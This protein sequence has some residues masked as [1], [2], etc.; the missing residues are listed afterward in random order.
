MGATGQLGN[1]STST[2]LVPV[3]VVDLVSVAGSVSVIAAG[4]MSTCAIARGR[5]YCWGYNS[6]GQ[7]G[8]NS[9]TNSSVPLLVS[10]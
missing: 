7:L 9:T 1:N 3:H 4:G 2:S 10:F 6:Y 5:A 8:N